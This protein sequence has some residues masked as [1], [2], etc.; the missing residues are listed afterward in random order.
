V[1]IQAV[2]LG[3]TG[4]FSSSTTTATYL[5]HL[6]FAIYLSVLAVQSIGKN[7]IYSHTR[8]IIHISALTTLAFVLLGFTALFPRDRTSISAPVEDSQPFFLQVVWYVVLSLYSL[9]TVVAVT[10]PLGPALH[11][12]I[13]RIYSEK[14]V[15]AVTN[16]AMDNV[17][18]V[19]GLYIILRC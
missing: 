4:F 3:Y 2:S 13:S 9:S 14:T 16:H 11:F 12:P 1:A 8:N 5:L 19:T 10:T 18:G 15:A 17:S 6:L 7:T